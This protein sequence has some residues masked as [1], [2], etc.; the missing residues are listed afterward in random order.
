MKTTFKAAL[1]AALLA[2][3][4]TAALAQEHDHGDRGGGPRPAAPAAAPAAQPQQHWNGGGMRQGGPG[5]NP[6]FRG[7]GRGEGF[8]RHDQ[9]QEFQRRDRSQEFQGQAFQRHDQAPAFQGQ[10]FQGG[11]AQRFNRDGERH[12]DH[13]RGPSV[14]TPPTAVP[15]TAQRGWDG[16]RDGR[17]VAGGFDARDG[18][19]DDGRWANGGERH[20][21]GAWSGRDGHWAHGERWER[22]R[23]PSVVSSH[24]RFHV[25]AYRAPYGFFARSWGFGDILP[26]G[27]YGPDYFIDDFLDFDLPYPPPGYEWVRVGPDALMIDEYTG[28]IVQVVRGIFW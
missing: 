7:E 18:R 28:R 23:F 1:A 22:G 13:E 5:G 12:W 14:V 25:G 3:T 6:G 2:G 20:R 10:R 9:G 19:H 11:D 27:W 16:R 15:P 26:R 8:Q 24:H 4:A 21:D 17:G